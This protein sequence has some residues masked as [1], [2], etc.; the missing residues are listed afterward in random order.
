MVRAH[1]KKA[2]GLS[3]LVTRD[4]K[5][6]KFIRV[7]STTLKNT[8]TAI[9][10]WEKEPDVSA[11]KELLDRAIDRPKETLEIED[12]T[13]WDAFRA[14]IAAARQRLSLPKVPPSLPKGKG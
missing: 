5:T 9:E 10:V 2:K 1:I 11:F 3:Y 7:T 8:Q 6:G 13:D 4:A 12:K 14:R